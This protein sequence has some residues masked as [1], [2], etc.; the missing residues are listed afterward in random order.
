MYERM[1]VKLHAFIS[2]A[3]QYLERIGLLQALLLALPTDEKICL[4]IDWKVM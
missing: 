1:E 4:P 2:A 3:L